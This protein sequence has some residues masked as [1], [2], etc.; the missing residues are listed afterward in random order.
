MTAALAPTPVERNEVA[1]AR[2]ELFSAL[3]DELNR[4]AVPYCLLSGYENFPDVGDSD[5]DFMVQP[6]DEARVVPVLQSVARRRGALLVQAL[7]HETG[8]CYFVLAKPVADGVAYLHPDCTTDYR[9]DGRLWLRADEILRGRRRFLNFYVPASADEFLYYLIKKVLKLDFTAQHLQHLRDRY[10]RSPQECTKRMT[11]FWPAKTV[12]TVVSALLENDLWRLR[13]NLPSLSAELL[14][15]PLIEPLSA[16]ATQWAREWKRRV[17]RVA[18]PTGLTIVIHGGNASQ[19]PELAAAL[20]TN[21]RPAFRRTVVTGDDSSVRALHRWHA[22]VRS[23]L[24]IRHRASSPPGL[25]APNQICFDLAE[26]PL[27][28]RSAT[29]AALHWLSRRLQNRVAG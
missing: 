6:G 23:T 5:I 21:L 17:S 14:A 8:A 16:R 27:N 3:V 1:L 2:A 19:R 12:R 26:A 22:M 24:V 10:E 18:R 29:E 25:F 28:V 13:W 4:S 20:E 15:S 9:R 11:R 7:Q